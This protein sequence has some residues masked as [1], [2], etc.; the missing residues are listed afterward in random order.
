M[1][2]DVLIE[3]LTILNV[4]VCPARATPRVN[5]PTP[6]L[7][8]TTSFIQFI[9]TRYLRRVIRIEVGKQ[10][11]KVANIEIQASLVFACVIV[12]YVTFMIHKLAAVEVN[13]MTSLV[14]CK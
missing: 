13:V 2:Y 11:V 6:Q 14:S 12:S 1:T 8:S 4:I 7:K 3:M 5:K 9:S 10:L